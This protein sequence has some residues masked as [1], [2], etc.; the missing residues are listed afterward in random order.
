MA[1]IDRARARYLASKKSAKKI[2]KKP[3]M[4]SH[5]EKERSKYFQQEWHLADLRQAVMD[6]QDQ[7]KQEL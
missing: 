5:I 1:E 4:V 6:E 2:S 3:K 7:W